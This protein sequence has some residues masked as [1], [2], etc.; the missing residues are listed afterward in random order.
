[1]IVAVASAEIAVVVA[2]N[3]AVVAEAAT[4]TDAGTVSCPLLSASATSAPPL[5]AAF[6]RVTV[7]VLDAFGP[8]L[9]GL[10]ATDETAVAAVRLSVVFA[11]V[12][13]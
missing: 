10:Q 8:M 2:L 11:E 5:G 13:L 6:D 12:E 9:E 1:M 3:V 4:V 7:Q